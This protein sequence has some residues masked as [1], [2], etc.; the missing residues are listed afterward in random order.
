M[1]DTRVRVVR[2]GARR[3][4]GIPAALTA[5][6]LVLGALLPAGAHAA[7]G[8]T[9][10]SDP[11]ASPTSALPTSTVTLSVTYRNR[12][13]SAPDFVRVRV[14][15]ATHAMRPTVATETWK[16]GVR[17]TVS[18][19][20]PL[21]THVPRFEASDRDKFSDAIDGPTIVVRSSLSTPTPAPTPKPAPI[22]TPV[23]GMPPSPSP[24]PTIAPVPPGA[25]PWPG[26]WDPGDP[27][28]S[29]ATPLPPPPA[30]TMPLYEPEEPPEPTPAAVVPVF[31]VPAG[32]G[33]GAQGPG[34]GGGPGAGGGPG[35]DP[36]TPG[37]EPAF[38][39]SP[40]SLGHMVAT[41]VM[42]A[43][44]AAATTSAVTLTMAFLVF[45]KR[46]R[47]GEPT[48][49]D[50]V[51]ADA[52]ATGAGVVADGALTSSRGPVPATSVVGAG[53]VPPDAEAHLPRWRRPSLLEARKA[54]P[55]RS[56]TPA[57]RLTF[58]DGAAVAVPDA[59]RR[60]IRYRLV[61]L[62]DL[63]DEVRGSEI[64][65]LDEGDEVVLLEKQGTYWRVLCPDGREG[66]LHKMTLGDTVIGSSASD[67]D[68]WTGADEDLSGFESVL[69]AYQLRRGEL[70]GA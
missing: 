10:L 50:E 17:Y 46:R 64:G 3:R 1:E 12:E 52:A 47:A 59:E 18:L 23:P 57:V 27:A 51:L 69:R 32:P 41:L 40:R 20:L 70:P 28:G 67:G 63:P 26:T 24:L 5:A 60:R 14:A 39:A 35:P 56:A 21:G 2:T 66:W 42:A 19:R 31:P 54:D 4:S 29:G 49:S 16:R 44:V 62:L 25:S 58:D 37:D 53:V 15:G 36:V 61:R 68:T 11:A 55:L 8:P 30:P 45:G 9:Q 38:G 34:T 65:V 43:P 7:S 6:L 33:G 22:A 13:G 48:A